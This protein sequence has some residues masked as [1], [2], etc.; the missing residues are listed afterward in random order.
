MA[1]ELTSAQKQAF[2]E[3]LDELGLEAT[4]VVASLT[5]GDADGP[6]YLTD[7]PD[8]TSAVPAHTITVEHVD[9]LKRLAGVPDADYDNG[10]MEHH[11]EELPRWLEEHNDLPL[12]E[13]TLAQR[14]NMH[15]AFIAYV[16]G[17]SSR[18]SSYLTAINQHHFPFTG[19]AYAVLDVTV[20]PGKPL[21]I[22]GQNPGTNFG[23]V[24]I[25]P[26]GQ[27]IIES[28]TAVNIQ[29]LIVQ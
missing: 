25:E 27:M 29:Q 15:H 19:T 2:Q 28:D 5:T 10:T 1:A 3:R 21:I 14:K 17:D 20:S 26:G 16:Y 4:D 22:G 11:H 13:L 18:V 23:I 7:D 24:T 6:T 12:K 9:D 8:R